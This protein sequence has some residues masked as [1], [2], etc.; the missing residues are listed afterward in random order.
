MAFRIGLLAARL[1]I[2]EYFRGASIGFVSHKTADSAG[3][4]RTIRQGNC[5][6]KPRK[7]QKGGRQER[8]RTGRRQVKKKKRQGNKS[9]LFI[10]IRLQRMIFI[11][12]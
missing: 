7:V 11:S 5:Q 6:Q 3:R 8:G 9:C 10:S 1:P 2:Y 4:S 12:D